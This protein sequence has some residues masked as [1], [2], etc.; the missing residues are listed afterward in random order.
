MHGNDMQ[1]EVGLID[2]VEIE[3]DTSGSR[4]RIQAYI[5][6]LDPWYT[7]GVHYSGFRVKKSSLE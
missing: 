7:V 3:E 6:T 4:E 1:V 2:E 5:L